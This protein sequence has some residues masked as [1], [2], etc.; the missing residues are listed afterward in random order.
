MN[1][2]IYINKI[3]TTFKILKKAT[4]EREQDEEMTK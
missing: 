4:N 2:R 1:A 3:K